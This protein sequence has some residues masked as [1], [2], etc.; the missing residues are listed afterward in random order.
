MLNQ[1][2]SKLSLHIGTRIGPHL[3]QKSTRSRTGPRRSPIWLAPSPPHE[4]P[5][6]PARLSVALGAVLGVSKPLRN[7]ALRCASR[8]AS[9]SAFRVAK[10]VVMRAA[11]LAAR[12]ADERGRETRRGVEVA[13]VGVSKCRAR[14]HASN[15]RPATFHAAA[16]CTQIRARAVRPS[17]ER[18][19]WRSR[20]AGRR[21]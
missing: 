2:L 15:R 14:H 12:F 11:E 20:C 7:A 3:T 10:F 9:A 6:R 4:H 8:G 13:G 17:A 18:A 19:G 5:R 16:L 21:S 1:E